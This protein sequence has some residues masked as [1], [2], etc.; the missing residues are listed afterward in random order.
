MAFVPRVVLL[1]TGR[2]APVCGREEGDI[3]RFQGSVLGEGAT[4]TS[5]DVLASNG[6]SLS[7]S[8]L[9][10]QMLVQERDGIHWTCASRARRLPQWKASCRQPRAMTSTQQPRGRAWAAAR[11]EANRIGRIRVC[12][13]TRC[14]THSEREG[15]RAAKP[16]PATWDACS[17]PPAVFVARRPPIAIAARGAVESFATQRTSVS[18]C[19]PTCP[20]LRRVRRLLPLPPGCMGWWDAFRGLWRPCTRHETCMGRTGFRQAWCPRSVAGHGDDEAASQARRL[21]SGASS[22]GL[23]GRRCSVAQVLS[24]CLEIRAPI[25]S[26]VAHIVD[27]AFRGMFPWRASGGHV[28]G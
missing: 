28:A 27:H 15:T 26:T 22:E 12:C 20:C 7:R 21:C 17:S 11:R 4:W 6:S 24:R 16:R 25:P 2:P 23:F 9:W 14:S 5:G 1:V 10:A 13:R 19:S 18:E 8:R 3:H